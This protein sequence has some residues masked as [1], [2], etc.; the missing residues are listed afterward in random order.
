MSG[1]R[2]WP[3]PTGR[4]RTLKTYWGLTWN[5]RTVEHGLYCTLS[6]Q[7]SP[8]QCPYGLYAEQLSG[9]AFTVPRG[10]NERSWLYRIRPSVC[11]TPFKKLDHVYFTNNF[12]DDHPNPNQVS[13]NLFEWWIGTDLNPIS[14]LVIKQW[15]TLWGQDE[16][17]NDMNFSYMLAKKHLPQISIKQ[18]ANTL[19]NRGRCGLMMCLTRDPIIV[20]LITVTSWTTSLATLGKS[21]YFVGLV[22]WMRCKTQIPCIWVSMPGRGNV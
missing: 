9:T 15:I 5:T 13:E 20:G 18:V 6:F 4:G 10:S 3:V 19:I 2:G 1:G 14:C 12:V 16:F 11:H 21:L 7:N 22:L 17:G 8:Q